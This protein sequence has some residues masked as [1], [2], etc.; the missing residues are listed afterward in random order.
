M[1]DAADPDGAALPDLTRFPSGERE[2]SEFIRR[3]A[4]S[5]DLAERHFIELKSDI[6]PTS[7]EGAAKVA[8]FVLGAANRDPERAKKY[9]EGHAVMILGVSEDNVRGLERFEAKDLVGAVQPYVGEPGPRWDFQRIRVDDER[10]VI[11]ITV[12][13][14][15]AGDPI[16]PCCREGVGLIDGRIYIRA[17][18]ETREAKSGEIRALQARASA[19]AGPRPDLTVALSGSV[20]RFRCDS[21]VLDEHLARER[22]RLE[23]H[24]PTPPRSTPAPPP[25]Q[26]SSAADYLSAASTASIAS[27][28]GRMF[29]A[30]TEPDPRSREEYLAE[31]N[32]WEE[33]VRGAWLRFASDFAIAVTPPTRIEVC[34]QSYLEEVKIRIR[35]DGPVRARQ[36]PPDPSNFDDLPSPPRPWSP[37]STLPVSLINPADYLCTIGVPNTA[38]Y[39]AP[40]VY[41]RYDNIE[42]DN[43]NSVYLTVLVE[44]LRPQDLYVS[45]DELTLFVPFDYDGSTITGTWTVTAKNH[46]RQ[47]SG[48]LQL[49]VDDVTDVT[50][51][52]RECLKPTEDQHHDAR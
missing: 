35:L 11:V 46:H 51:S 7:K 6:D 29:G 9:L 14:P 43:S 13:P 21:S 33:K 36:R 48:E 49:E 26:M 23:A 39:T 44:E 50:E 4:A 32:E 27:S 52:L 24:A 16:W 3:V 41:S 31:I 22:Q 19:A 37:R 42:I 2:W 12:V 34:S 5:G 17:D 45:S 28:V 25:P 18:G 20:R 8:K 40:R 38:S 47:Y 15:Q 1:A 30:T 10:D